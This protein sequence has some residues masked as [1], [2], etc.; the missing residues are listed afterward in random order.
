MEYMPGLCLADCFEQL[1]YE[2]KRRTA[3]DV[4]EI[5]FSLF[6][7]TSVQCGSISPYMGDSFRSNESL[8]H[9][10]LRYPLFTPL[11]SPRPT[12]TLKGQSVIVGPINDLTFLDYPRQVDPH[13]CGPFNSER[14]FME[15]FAFLGTPPTRAGGKLSCWVFEKTLEVYN[16]VRNLYYETQQSEV[17]SSNHD[18]FHFAH[19]DLSDFNILIDPA[20]GAVTGV[21]DWEMAGFHP[22]WL[23]AVAGGWFDDDS[24][25][26]L[27]S[28]FQSSRENHADETPADAAL[29]AHFRLRL[30]TLDM[31]LFRH[32]L[33]GIELRALFYACCNEC[34]GNTEMWL[35]KYKDQEWVVRRRGNFPFDLVAWIEERLDL[36]DRWVFA[37]VFSF[38]LMS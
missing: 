8:C 1:T 7:I 32:H 15:A 22:A 6:N 13:L 38:F 12:P 36:E 19:G 25:R 26:F 23:A 4:A 27:M 14:G 18:Q 9:N 16:V 28:D 33:Q 31:Q 35:E 20:T 30:A 2:Q 5:M 29:R 24:E 21:I 17:S 34:G 37:E 10:S 11:F 3:T